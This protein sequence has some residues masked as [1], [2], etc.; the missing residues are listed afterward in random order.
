MNINNFDL[1]VLGLGNPE[2][3]YLNTRHNIGWNCVINLIKKYAKLNTSF[4]GILK[5]PTTQKKY[6]I[7]VVIRNPQVKEASGGRLAAPVVK[8]IAQHILDLF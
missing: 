5:H 4:I 1:L 8:K 3:K 2:S 6:I 7:Y